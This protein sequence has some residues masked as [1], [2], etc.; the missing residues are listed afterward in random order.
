[1]RT[2]QKDGSFVCEFGFGRV[3]GG[4]LPTVFDFLLF[5]CD[6]GLPAGL[7]DVEVAD[8]G[9][10]GGER[11]FERLVC[12]NSVFFGT[13]VAGY[14]LLEQFGVA[15]KCLVQ[16]IVFELFLRFLWTQSIVFELDF[17]RRRVLLMVPE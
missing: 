14:L 3:L 15:A 13:A 11:I 12:G 2:L 9:A 6:F 1:M 17:E 10:E 7:L 5:A 8:G 16:D 4:E